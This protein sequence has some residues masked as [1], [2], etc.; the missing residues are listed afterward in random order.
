M[1]IDTFW[2]LVLLCVILFL[3]HRLVEMRKERNLLK[4]DRDWQYQRFCISEEQLNAKV[5]TDD[6][7]TPA[8]MKMDAEHRFHIAET[9]LPQG[10]RIQALPMERY[11]KV[12]PSAEDVRSAC[13]N[14]DIC[15]SG[16]IFRL[17]DVP[18]LCRYRVGSYR[19]NKIYGEVSPRKEYDVV[20]CEKEN[21]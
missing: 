9:I 5:V 7:I 1:T 2:L 13:D 6:M 4:S 15:Q 17:S 19:E 8:I 18:D 14:C 20:V 12:V 16:R 10:Y 3:V 11:Y 21:S